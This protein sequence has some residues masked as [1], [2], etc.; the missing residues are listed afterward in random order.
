M[1]L[2]RNLEH[3]PGNKQPITTL[4]AIYILVQQKYEFPKINFGSLFSI[5]VLDI[6]FNIFHRYLSW[7]IWVNVPLQ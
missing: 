1:L 6:S 5:Y 7:F 2:F 3:G 4:G